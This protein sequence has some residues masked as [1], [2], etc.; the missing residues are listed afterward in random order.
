MRESRKS[1]LSGIGGALAIAVVAFF[2]IFSLNSLQWP[3]ASS[4]SKVVTILPSPSS[5]PDGVLIVY[6]QSNLTVFPT[7][8]TVGIF[9]S[10]PF[11]GVPSSTPLSGVKV[12][13][14]Q[15]LTA[16]I[17]NY[18]DSVGQA[19]EDLAPGTYTVKLLDWRLNNLSTTVQVSSDKITQLSVVVNA[20]SYSIQSANIVDPDSSGWAVSWGQ[21][22]VEVGA[23]VSVSTQN[24]QIFLDTLYSPFTPLSRIQEDGVT[25]ITIGSSTS[26]SGGSQWVQIQVNSP[27]N[28]SSI[29]SMSILTLRAGY[30][31]DN[32]D[33]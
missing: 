18:T 13:V 24:P 27:V 30:K 28:I 12:A 26:S 9:Y 21:I 4:L 2:L 3:L 22:F 25:P 29:K 11:S 33:Y 23:N 6:V 32:Y 31:V 16:T 7:N 1:Q 5:I 8:Q 20:T 19:Q 17:S 15:G 10:P 14:F